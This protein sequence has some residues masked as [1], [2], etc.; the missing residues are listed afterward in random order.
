MKK[1]TRGTSHEKRNHQGRKL[2]GGRVT[3][4]K[5]SRMKKISRGKSHEKKNHE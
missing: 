3:R 5:K 4:E 1:I 2:Q